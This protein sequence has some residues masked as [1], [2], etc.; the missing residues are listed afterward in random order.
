MDYWGRGGGG[1][2]YVAPSQI[3]GGLAPSSYAYAK[4]LEY[5]CSRGGRG[6]EGANGPAKS[7]RRASQPPSPCS[8]GAHSPIK[9]KQQGS[10]FTSYADRRAGSGG[11]TTPVGPLSPLFWDL[12]PRPLSGCWHGQKDTYW[13][14]PPPWDGL[15]PSPARAPGGEW[16][17]SWGRLCVDTSIG[18]HCEPV[19]QP[20]TAKPQHTCGMTPEKRAQRQPNSCSTNFHAY[21]VLTSLR[22]LIH[23]ND[24]LLTC[25]IYNVAWEDLV[26]LYRIT[27]VHRLWETTSKD[28]WTFMYIVG[29]RNVSTPYLMRAF[30][31]LYGEWTRFWDL[32]FSEQFK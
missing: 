25:L 26:S 14:P 12:K 19:G 10:E 20:P 31:F 28:R 17:L 7:G 9:H 11:Q 2:G 22:S 18:T 30:S 8:S 4:S 15:P 32:S 5:I 24:K 27:L 6:W 29:K 3:I 21:Q 13:S 1:K 16:T 23:K